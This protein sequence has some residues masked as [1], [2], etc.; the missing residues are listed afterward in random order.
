MS[1][2]TNILHKMQDFI[3]QKIQHYKDI[4]EFFYKISGRDHFKTIKNIIKSAIM[5]LKMHVCQSM[6]DIQCVQIHKHVYDIQYQIHLKQY[7]IRVQ[8]KKGPSI[9]QHFFDQDGNNI[10]YD[11]LPYLGPN[12][13]FH[14]ISYTPNDFGHTK[15]I[16]EY[17]DGEKRSFEKDDGII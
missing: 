12:Q 17:Q 5:V 6:I 15:I 7:K 11:I 2:E 16:V 1:K 8:H 13:D 9:Y 14:G 10:T 4:Y 3:S